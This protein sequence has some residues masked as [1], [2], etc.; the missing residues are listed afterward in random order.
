M[1]SRRTA[2][3]ER[4]PAL[5]RCL[6]LFLGALFLLPLAVDAQ[7]FGRNK[8]QYD[9]FDFEVLVTPHFNLH[10]YPE[11]AEVAEDLAR[12]SERWYERLARLFQHE[13][14]DRKPLI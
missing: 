5:G 8:V 11:K 13:F 12:M 4:G 3:H 2:R 10:F 9:T 6:V 1:H 7:Y 14:E